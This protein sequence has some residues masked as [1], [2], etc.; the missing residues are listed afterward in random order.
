MSSRLNPYV[1]WVKSFVPK[2][3]N[4]ACSA[5]S[6]AVR[7]ALGSSI[8]VPIRQLNSTPDSL[9]YS[10]KKDSVKHFSTPASWIRQE[11]GVAYLERATK[12]W[13]VPVET[14]FSDEKI[15]LQ[16]RLKLYIKPGLEII[17]KE[18]GK[19]YDDSTLEDILSKYTK[20]DHY[21]IKESASEEEKGA[22]L[23]KLSEYNLVIVGVHKYATPCFDLI[24]AYY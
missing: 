11:L 15:D 4:S 1:V 2:L 7:H 12:E 6:S 18:N 14:E 20:V 21:K 13:C 9:K 8:M 10:C 23:S 17:L 24:D 22:I 3:K 5:I 19:N 16:E